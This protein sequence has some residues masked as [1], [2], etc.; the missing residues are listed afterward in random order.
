MWLYFRVI[1]TF[2]L[3]KLCLHTPT[4]DVQNELAAELEVL[5]SPLVKVLLI[6]Y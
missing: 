3:D 2:F 1:V 5:L 4:K 6:K